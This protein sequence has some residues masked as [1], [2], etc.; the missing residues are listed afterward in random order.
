MS[1][2]RPSRLKVLL[3]P[4]RQRQ[5][6]ARQAFADLRQQEQ[7]LAEG[8]RRCRDAMARHDDWARAAVL[9]GKTTG[10]AAYRMWSAELAGELAAKESLLAGVRVKLQARRV[11]LAQCMKETKAM[12]RV[13]HRQEVVAATADSHRQTREMDHLHAAQSAWRMDSDEFSEEAAGI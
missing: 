12:D 7:A 2:K 10:L 6:Q 1:E 5:E 3:R 8:I 11:E 13:I 9:A 4:A